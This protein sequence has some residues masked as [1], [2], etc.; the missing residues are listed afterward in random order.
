MLVSLGS[1]VEVYDADGTLCSLHDVYPKPSSKAVVEVT[2]DP[3]GTVGKIRVE[4]SGFCVEGEVEQKESDQITI[5]K[6]SYTLQEGV[7]FPGKEGDVVRIYG[8]DDVI[9]FAD[10]YKRQ[11]VKPAPFLYIQ[12]GMYLCI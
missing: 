9:M 7:R 1:E 3:D 2:I 4:P 6:N 12:V 10:V 11:R 8:L 5:D